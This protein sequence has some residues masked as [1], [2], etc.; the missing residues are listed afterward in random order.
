MNVLAQVLVIGSATLTGGVH[1]PFLPAVVMPSIV[2][3]LFFGPHAVARWSAVA[4]GLFIIAMV[5]AAARGRRPAAARASNYTVASR[6]SGSA[7]TS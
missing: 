6:C 7:G 1:S 2:S 5:V 4:N 3:L